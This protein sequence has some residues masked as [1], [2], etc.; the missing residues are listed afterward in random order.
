MNNKSK[1][2][3]IKPASAKWFG[4]IGFLI[5]IV[6][7]TIAIFLSINQEKEER[8]SKLN[9]IQN[10]NQTEEASSILSKNVNEVK[11]KE[12][13]NT[14]STNE[15][16]A[17]TNNL[18]SQITKNTNKNLE[19]SKEQELT[20]LDEIKNTTKN[21]NSN[22]NTTNSN[23]ESKSNNSNSNKGTTSNTINEGDDSNEKA[24]EKTNTTQFAKPAEGNVSNEFSMDSLIYSNTLQEWVTH[25]GID[26]KGEL[27]ANVIAIADGTVT[28]IKNDPRYGLSITIEHSDGFK[29]VYSCLLSTEDGLEEGTK[30]SQGQVIAKMGNSG[31]FES[32]DGAHLHFEL[33]QNGEYVNPELYIK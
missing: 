18:N 33:M 19:I 15:A 13:L 10:L 26:I 3:E 4:I 24:N 5:A 20:D 6:L 9:E 27:E 12:I 31:V 7:L 21:T 14:S 11:A 23:N 32:E 28:S 29:S 22:V 8:L 30:I 1:S 16:G 2:D 17:N 25:R